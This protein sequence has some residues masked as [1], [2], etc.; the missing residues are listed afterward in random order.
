MAIRP[1]PTRRP[2]DGRATTLEQLLA[3][4]RAQ[5][6]ADARRHAE[7]DADAEEALCRRRHNAS[8][9]DLSVMPTLGRKAASQAMIVQ[10]GSA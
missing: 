4:K 2:S 9:A 6:L 5:L 3:A 10:M 7:R 1:K 8:Y